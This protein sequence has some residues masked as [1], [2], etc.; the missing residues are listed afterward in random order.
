MR[1]AFTGS[2][3]IN[4]HEV[5]QNGALAPA[6]LTSILQGFAMAHTA[7]HGHTLAWFQSNSLAWLL[8]RWHFFIYTIPKFNET[9]LLST[10]ARPASRTQADRSFTVKSSTDEL[11]CTAESRWVLYDVKRGRPAKLLATE[12]DKYHC[13]SPP[14]IEGET[15]KLISPANS[16]INEQKRSFTVTRRDI[17][18]N[19]HVNNSS[20]IHWAMDEIPDAVY[21]NLSLNELRV[22]YK[23]ECLPGTEVNSCCS[24][25]EV[26]SG[27]LF[28]SSFS[29][30]CTIE[31][32][33]N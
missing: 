24:E 13:D 29:P 30:Y 21:N 4:Y 25:F 6:S 15:F 2:Y 28:V 19:Q 27:K 31:S 16:S 22:E 33:W 26:N 20:Y 32:I 12:F 7:S 14:A 9:V 8:L 18:T 10:W 11:L 5:D 17:D 3:K 23:K 1:K